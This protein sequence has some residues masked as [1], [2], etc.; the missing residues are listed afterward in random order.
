[1]LTGPC[2]YQDYSF[3][4]AKITFTNPE[5]VAVSGG[6]ISSCDISLYPSVS[7]PSPAKVHR[8][9]LP[10]YCATS[11]DVCA[12]FQEQAATYYTTMQ[13]VADA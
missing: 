5:C 8:G 3:S 10:V 13:V 9:V 2:T 7:S 12:L 1:M 6:H 4:N 11:A